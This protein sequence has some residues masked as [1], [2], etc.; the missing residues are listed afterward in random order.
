MAP[1]D[2]IIGR[3]CEKYHKLPEE[4]EGSDV[5]RLMRM[6]DLEAI[7]DI[8]EKQSRGEKL[9]AREMKTIQWIMQEDLRQKKLA[10]ARK[11]KAKGKD[12]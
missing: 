1:Y 5:A 9:N 10:A 8:S 7:Y 4:I 3:L 12:A 11:A 2:L 6:G